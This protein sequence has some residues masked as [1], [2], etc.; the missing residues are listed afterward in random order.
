M[1]MLA[2]QRQDV[3][4]AIF[5]L[6]GDAG[7]ARDVAA[8]VM[9]GQLPIGACPRLHGFDGVDDFLGNTAADICALRRAVLAMVPVHDGVLRDGPGKLLSPSETRRKLA[10]WPLAL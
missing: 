6:R 10:L 9:P 5:V 8:V 2:T 3:D 4:A 7:R 1:F